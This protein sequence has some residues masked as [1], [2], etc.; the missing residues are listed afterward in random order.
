MT[1]QICEV[2]GAVTEKQLSS[3]V[4]RVYRSTG[5]PLYVWD[6]G[7]L[8]CDGCNAELTAVVRGVLDAAMKPLQALVDQKRGE[9][10]LKAIKAGATWNVQAGRLITLRGGE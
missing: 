2:C 8:A 3:V 5:N 6:P 10:R 4:I 1:I 7:K 9:A